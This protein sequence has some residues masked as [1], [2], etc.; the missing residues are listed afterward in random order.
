M[1]EW[2]TPGWAKELAPDERR[3]MDLDDAQIAAFNFA[4][5]HH[6]IKDVC[7]HDGGR[8]TG[9]IVCARLRADH[10]LPAAHR[11]GKNRLRDSRS[12]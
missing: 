3:V 9:G 8:F 5:Q 7:P 4:G 12:D 11:N 6:A 1:S 10:N 2:L